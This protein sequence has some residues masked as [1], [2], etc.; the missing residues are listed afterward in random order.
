LIFCLA[1]SGA[2]V[3]VAKN[4]EIIAK[5]EGCNELLFQ[6]DITGLQFNIAVRDFLDRKFS[7]EMMAVPFA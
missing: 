4:D 6:Q 2:N 5:E 3:A 1:T 7:T